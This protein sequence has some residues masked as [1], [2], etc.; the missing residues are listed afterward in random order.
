MKSTLKKKTPKI[1]QL[2]AAPWDKLGPD[3][4]RMRTSTLYALCDDGSVLTR[5]YNAELDNW[6]WTDTVIA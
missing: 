6:Y 4:K 2:L 5:I 3:G 1:I